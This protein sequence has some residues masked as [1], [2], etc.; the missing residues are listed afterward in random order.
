MLL[1]A[2]WR[3]LTNLLAELEEVGHGRADGS[4]AAGKGGFWHGGILTSLKHWH[5]SYGFLS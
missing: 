2:V 4:D 1:I 5:S 3:L